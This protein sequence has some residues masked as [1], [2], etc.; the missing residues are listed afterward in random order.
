MATEVEVADIGGEGL[1]ELERDWRGIEREASPSP[2]Q[3][4]DWLDAWARAYE[5]RRLSGVRVRDA[6]GPL[7]GIGVIEHAPGG[8]W[9]FGGGTVTPRRG[10]LCTPGS[11]RSAWEAL[12]GWLQARP[13]AFASLDAD[14]LEPASA[15]RNAPAAVRPGEPVFALDLPTSFDDYLAQRS[16][17]GRKG[18]KRKLRRLDVEDG[19]VSA[20]A[21]GESRAALEEWVQLH[22]RRAADKG[23][24]H[25]GFDSRLA[26]LVGSLGGGALEVRL[27]VL[28]VGTRTAGVTVRLDTAATGTF[29]NAGIDPDLMRLSPGVMLELASIRDAIERG[30][31]RFDLGPGAY[32]YKTDLGGVATDRFDLALTSRSSRGRLLSG[33]RRTAGA[34]RRRAP[35]RAAMR[36]LRRARAR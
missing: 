20:V 4:W 24:H 8:R 16:P 10:L 12:V 23:E 35:G 32:R 33:V 9:R 21:G 29:Y 22:M 31:R 7:A 25:A 34:A 14:G 11:E 17:S 27:L 26:T 6:G 13:R 19:A 15:P 18:L 1:A 3:T 30:L 2:F 36:R 5:P 28:K